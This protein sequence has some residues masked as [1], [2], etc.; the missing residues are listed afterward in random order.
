MDAR[1]LVSRA[2]IEVL[3]SVERSGIVTG[4]NADHTDG[5]PDPL[6]YPFSCFV[7]LTS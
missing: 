4:S 5:S 3:H 7:N 6:S 1:K 2:I